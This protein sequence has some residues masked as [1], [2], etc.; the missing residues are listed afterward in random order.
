MSRIVDEKI[1]F[2]ERY[3]FT[4]DAVHYSEFSVIHEMHSLCY[5]K[6]KVH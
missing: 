6:M 5:S 2:K 1:I 3:K 4:T